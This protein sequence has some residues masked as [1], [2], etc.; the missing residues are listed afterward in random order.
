M[1]KKTIKLEVG[2]PP[3]GFP[4]AMYF[5]RFHIEREDAFYFVQFGLVSN[6]V[7]LDNYSCVFSTG[8]LAQNK[9]TLLNYLSRIGRPMANS[10]P[11]WKG[12]AVEKPT[13]VV[14]VVTMAFRDETAETC[15]FVFSMGAA[16][17]QPK[18]DGAGVTIPAQALAI[19]RST[20][21][22]QKMLIVGLYE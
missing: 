7:L 2:L 9:D 21:E 1:D 8:T 14:D 18:S 13:D 20:T 11:T 12:T 4:R 5:N 19:L 6:S 3:I 10:P 22:M 16:T 15:L 17:R